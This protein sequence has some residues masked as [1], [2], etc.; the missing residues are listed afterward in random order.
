MA[1]LPSPAPWPIPPSCACS[2]RS[3]GST[4]KPAAVLAQ[5]DDDLS[6][7]EFLDRGGFSDYFA[8]H[9]LVPIVSCVWSVAPGVALEYPARYLFTFL[10]NHGMLS[11][12]G[13]PTWRT[14]VGGLAP[15]STVWSSTSAQCRRPTPVRAVIER[16][17]GLEVR[18]DDD[19]GV[20][21]D[22]V[23]M[24]THADTSLALLANPSHWQRSVLGAFGY[25]RNE[26]VLH[27][28]ATLLPIG[29]TEH[30]QPGIS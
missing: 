23:V 1:F 18:T 21:F 6:L 9:F 27:T 11:V 15:M 8:S 12:S 17:D 10:D 22:R 20:H 5:G 30:G 25:S 14:V 13:S 3:G 28:D 24:A 2:P 29:A 16:P 7:G 26:T 4:A 19:Q